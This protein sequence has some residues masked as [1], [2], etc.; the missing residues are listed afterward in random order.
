MQIHAGKLG[1]AQE[2]VP[3]DCYMTDPR[4][5]RAEH[6]FL[7]AVCFDPTGPVALQIIF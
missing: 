7:K 1:G 4:A 6:S 3:V 2:K 5:E